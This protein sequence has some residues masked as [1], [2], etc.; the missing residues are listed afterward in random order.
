MVETNP[1]TATL[2]QS[3]KT[4]GRLITAL[5]RFFKSLTVCHCSFQSFSESR[6]SRRLVAPLIFFQ[7]FKFHPAPCKG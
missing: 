3:A 4:V 6:G 1:A 7:D 2:Q 5:P